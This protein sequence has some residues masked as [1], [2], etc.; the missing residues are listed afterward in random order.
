MRGGTMN[1]ETVAIIYIVKNKL[2]IDAKIGAWLNKFYHNDPDYPW[3]RRA[4][5][6]VMRNAIND[7]LMHCDNMGLEVTRYFLCRDEFFIHDEFDA[8]KQFIH[9]IRIKHN[10]EYING[11]DEQQFADVINSTEG[12]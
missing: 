7:Y 4:I 3:D 8:M 2:A 9:L 12:I 6:K 11:F 5:E 10:D 1:F